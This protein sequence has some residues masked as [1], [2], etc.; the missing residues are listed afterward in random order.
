M[1]SFTFKISRGCAFESVQRLLPLLEHAQKNLKVLPKRTTDNPQEL[2]QLIE[3]ADHVLID[4][5]ERPMQR[6]QKKARQKN[7]TAEKKAFIP[8]KTP[9][10]QIPISAS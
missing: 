9:P 10:F 2:L 5:T 8:S 1:L 7:I 3:S 4:A 6:P